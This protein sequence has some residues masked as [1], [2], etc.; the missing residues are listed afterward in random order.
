MAPEG[1]DPRYPCPIGRKVRAKSSTREVW[2]WRGDGQYVSA[3]I[4]LEER[5]G[6][7]H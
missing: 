2:L 5:D 7:L 3:L 6:I 4:I 1:T